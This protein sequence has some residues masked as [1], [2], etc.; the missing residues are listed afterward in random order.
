[1]G[2]LAKAYVQIVPSAKGISG[3]IEKEINGNQI[4]SNAGKGIAG[5]IKAAIIAAGIGKVISSSLMEGADLEQ[6]LGGTEVV[7]GNFAKT[8]QTQAQNAYKNMG[9]SASDYMATANKMGSLFQGS[10][11]TQQKSLGL[12]SAAMQRA[13][14]VASV[15]GVDT[16]L[17]MESIAGAAKGNFTMMDNLGVA[18]NA[19]NLEAYALEKGINFKWNLASQAEKNELAMKMF[20]D[21]TSQYSGN[22]AREST[23][24]I[25]GSLGALVGSFKTVLGGMALG[26]DIGPSLEGLKIALVNAAM[27]VVPAIMNI[28]TTLPTALMNVISSLA[29]QIGPAAVTLITTFLGKITEMLPQLL[30]SGLSMIQGL[31]NGILQAIPTLVAALPQIITGIVNF[32][33]TSIPEIVTAGVEL[34]VSLIKNLPQITTSIVLAIPEIVTGLITAITNSIPEFVTA[35]VELLVSLIKDLPTIV[36]EIV[37]AIPDI[38]KGLLTALRDSIP[39][40]VSMGKDLLLG[41]AKGIAS[42]ISNVISAAIDAVGKV[43]D[44]VKDFFGIK[45]PSRVFMGIGKYLDE[46]LAKGISD[47]IGF[48]DRAMMELAGSATKKVDM[49]LLIGRGKFAL[50]AQGTSSGNKNVVVNQN[51]YGEQYSYAKQQR[52]AARQMRLVA[53]GI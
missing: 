41:L 52:E 15:M 2:D 27:N 30:T 25:S 12:T 23:E 39:K 46:G 17:A 9:M 51:I 26:Q 21:R 6:N 32:F 42:A 10:G 43:V 20:M 19:T 44:S 11:I 22:F 13:A 18:M 8:I 37:K 3:A 47:N 35:G 36:T 48:V 45:S 5:G 29:P 4:G 49:N 7:F 1:M 40:F 33:L 50:N 24:T 28:V 16:S 53:R 31:V 38:I 34:L 14:D